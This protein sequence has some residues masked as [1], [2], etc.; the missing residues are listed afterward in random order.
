[1]NDTL[2]SALKLGLAALVAIGITQWTGRTGTLMMALM[3]VVMFVNENETA[4][5]QRVVQIFWGAVIGVVCGLLIDGLHRGWLALAIALLATGLLVRLLRLQG[6]QAQAYLT[7]WAA[8][9]LMRGDRVE[10][11]V[12]F[13][14]VLPFLIGTLAAQA[15]NWLVW[16]KLRRR[17]LAA[18]DQSIAARFHHQLDGLQQWLRS[19]ESPPPL[20]HSSEVLPAIQQLQQLS[21]TRAISVPPA[22][23]QRWRQLGLL[24]RQVLREWLLLEPQLRALQVPLPAALPPLLTSTLEQIDQGLVTDATGIGSTRPFEEVEPQQWQAWGNAAGAPALV[25]LALGQQLEQLGRLLR[26]QA[27][28]RRCL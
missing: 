25:P 14:L 28:L 9:E 4:P 27:L 22:M 20:L 1:M 19:G 7:C 12:V 21:G 6:G 26:S 3:G 11:G 23:Q 15:A 5:V 10:I 16:P 2:R 13:N 17:R 18:L 24:W 8:L